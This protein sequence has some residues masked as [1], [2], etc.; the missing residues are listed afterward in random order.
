M[1]Y[2]VHDSQDVFDPALGLHNDEEVTTFRSMAE[3]IDRDLGLGGSLSFQALE[4]AIRARFL[5]ADA[6][7]TSAL[8]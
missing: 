7:R 2:L 5:I 8:R 3:A 6:G 1:S 4:T